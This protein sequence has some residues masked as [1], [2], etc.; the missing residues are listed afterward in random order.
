VPVNE[1]VGQA[2]APPGQLGVQQ[3]AVPVVPRSKPLGSIKPPKFNDTFEVYQMGLKLYL[4]Q[5]DPWGVVTGDETR[6]AFDPVLQRQFD[7]RNRLAMETIIRGVKGADA[8]KVCVCSTAREM[9][10]TLSAEKTQRDFSY[11]VHLKRELYTHSYVPGQKMADYIQ[12]MNTLRQWL[13]LMGVCAAHREIVT[14]FDFSYRQ[15]NPPS[16]QQVKNALL[17]RDEMER[18]AADTAVN[19]GTN[20]GDPQVAMH[21]GQHNGQYPGPNPGP[22][23][24]PGPRRGQVQTTGAGK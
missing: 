22:G 17:S 13:L 24:G 20:I 5:R 21:M 6:H 2:G 14:Q 9:W 23:P 19:C 4:E 8:Q 15:G 18:M 10:D 11:A 1:G 3:P 16:L 12:E 7:D